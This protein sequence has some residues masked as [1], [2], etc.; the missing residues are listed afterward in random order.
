ML[1]NWLAKLENLISTVQYWLFRVS[2]SWLHMQLPLI[3]GWGNR[4]RTE[5]KWGWNPL[6]L[7]YLCQ[8]LKE[9]GNRG[10]EGVMGRADDAQRQSA[11]QS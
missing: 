10:E 3:G 9:K 2:T 5:H 4:L 8:D 7:V 6:P 11:P 1:N